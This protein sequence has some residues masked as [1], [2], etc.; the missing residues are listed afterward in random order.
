M[1]KVRYKLWIVLLVFILALCVAVFI[2]I[3]GA[4]VIKPSA[5]IEVPDVISYRQDDPAWAEE[6]LGD[7]SYTMKTSGCLVTCIS[8]ALSY[9]GEAVT[10]G[11]F[12]MLFSEYG[13]YDAEANIQWTKL[14]ELE[15]FSVKVYDSVN[16]DDIAECLNNGLF[17]IVRV[18]MCGIGNYHYVL[19]VGSRNGE[20]ICMDP[21]KNDLTRLSDYWD[22]I[23]AIRCVWKENI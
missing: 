4:E 5:D 14:A 21:L 18:R 10:P 3:R 16:E 23:Y 6:S 1:K 8:S 7:S 19:I 12:N 20:Y 13:V 17:P 22:R 15:G 9:G 11:A 2:R